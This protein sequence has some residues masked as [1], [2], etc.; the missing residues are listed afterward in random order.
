MSNGWFDTTMPDVDQTNKLFATYLIQNTLWW[1]EYAGIDGIRMDTYPYPDKDFMA[2]W[3][4]RVL[5]EYPSFGLVG[6]VWINNAATTAYWQKNAKN[7]DGYE[8]G[9]PSVTD[10]PLYFAIPQALNEEGGWDTG[11]A[12]LYN[13]LSSDYVY[14]DAGNNL[15]FLDNHDLTRFYLSVGRD[16]KKF[17][18]GLAFLLT[19][20]GI[21]QL[22]YGS[23]LLMDG[24][25]GFH[26]NVRL[27]FPGGWKEDEKNAFQASGRTKEQNEAYEYMKKLLNWRKNETVIHAGK[28]THYIPQENIYVYFRYN[29]ERTVMVIMNGNQQDKVLDTKRF[30]ENLR[31]HKSGKDVITGLVYD[32][33]DTIKL[34]AQSVLVLELN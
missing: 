33:I 28:L 9:L 8:S 5:S 34:P 3:A 25:G 16:L 31:N 12:R 22:Y 15:I 10:F 21:P 11:L 23:E 19:T 29:E 14:P 18:M 7:A 24:D 26:P 32:S 30:T 27:D 6:E 2:A 13:V 20:R 1:I 17:K 4:K